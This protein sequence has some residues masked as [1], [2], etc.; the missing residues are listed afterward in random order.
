[1]LSAGEYAEG[2]KLLSQNKTAEIDYYYAYTKVADGETLTTNTAVYDITRPIIPTELMDDITIVAWLEKDGNRITDSESTFKIDFVHL[3]VP[4]TSLEASGKVE[5][6]SGTKYNILNDYP[7]DENIMLYY[8]LDGSDPSDSGNANRIKY[9]GEDL[10]LYRETTIK[11]VYFSSCGKCVECK[12]PN[13]EGCW[14]GIYGKTGTYKYTVPR[15]VT[16]GGGSS[17]GGGANFDKTRK[18]TVDIFGNEHPTHISYINGYP[19]GNVRPDGEVTRE[20]ITSILYRITNHAYE[21]PF[22]KTGVVFPDVNTDRWSSH[23]I[24]YMA[25]KNVVTGYPDGEFKPERSLSRAEFATLTYR[26][27]NR[28]KADIEN[29]FADIDDSHWAYSEILALY[30]SGLIDG[31]E[32]GTFKP[33]NNITRAE[34]M[35]VINKLLGRKPLESYVKSLSFNPYNDLFEE[36]WYYVT[37]L[38]ATITHNYWLDSKGYEYKWEDWK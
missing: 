8:T 13:K 20:E 14:Y 35:T 23:D 15:T 33:E 28:G 12:V 18:Y 37:I 5:F 1:M 22:I 38:E 36:K 3:K 17:G 6:A 29:P 9:N 27:T 21:Q 34:V 31:Y 10:F 7:A 32:D 16:I 24:E 26:F 2:I 11:A 4:T 25:E 19:D 30:K